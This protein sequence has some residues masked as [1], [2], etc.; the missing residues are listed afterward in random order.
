MFSDV[1]LSKFIWEKIR[2]LDPLPRTYTQRYSNAQALIGMRG[3]AKLDEYNA[4]AREHALRYTSGLSDCRSIQ[5]PRV[6]PDVEHVYYQYCIYTSD[7]RRVSRRAIRR[8]VDLETMHVDVCSALP[9]FKAFA[10]ACPEVEATEA[11]LQLPVYSRLRSSDVDRVSHILREVTRDLAP[12][13]EIKPAL[14]TRSAVAG[15]QDYNND[16]GEYRYHSL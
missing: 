1:D 15:S 3:L 7:P 14:S 12:F 16:S 9:L 5:T 13:V 8:G 11:A 4:R 6:L 2:P 10:A